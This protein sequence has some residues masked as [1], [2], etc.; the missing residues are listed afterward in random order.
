MS[1]A[2]NEKRVLYI[3]NIARSADENALV[4][5]FSQYGNVKDLKLIDRD[6]SQIAFV[7]YETTDSA[8][9]ALYHL[10][11]ADIH[12]VNIKVNYARDRQ[13]KSEK[14]KGEQQQTD[15]DKTKAE[16]TTK[17]PQTNQPKEKIE[18]VPTVI[19]RPDTPVGGTI[20]SSGKNSPSQKK[21][22]VN[23][24]EIQHP[25]VESPQ[26]NRNTTTDTTKANTNQQNKNKTTT[27]EEK[28]NDYT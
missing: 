1:T 18:K 24:K 20:K 3:S 5:R 14:K 27:Q 17:D 2:Q 4:S 23:A 12:G 16:D 28:K 9:F 6:R 7:E 11:N 13:D 15:D 8:A 25:K 26:T 22:K 19:E 21:Q 10:N